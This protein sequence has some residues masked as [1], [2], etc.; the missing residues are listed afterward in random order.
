MR[1]TSKPPTKAR[2]KP[3]PNTQLKTKLDPK[4]V[5]SDADLDAASGG[6]NPQPLPPRWR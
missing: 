1:K 2:T 6:L 5:L 4:A 3:Q